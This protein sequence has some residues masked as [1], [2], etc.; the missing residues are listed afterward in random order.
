MFT[1]VG[2]LDHGALFDLTFPSLAPEDPLFPAEQVTF[3]MYYG[4]AASETDALAA[5]SAVG[6]DLYTF[7]QPDV[8]GGAETG[9]PNTFIWAYRS[10][11]A[12]SASALSTTS[13]TTGLSLEDYHSRVGPPGPTPTGSPQQP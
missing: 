4:A 8:T 1:D 6:A 5:V 12:T 11:D 7:A 2:P 10:P 9:E 3:T 13:S